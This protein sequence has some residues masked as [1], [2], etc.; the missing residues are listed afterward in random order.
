MCTKTGVD[1]SSRFPFTVQTL[2]D[3]H[4]HTHEVT[5]A[6]D[7]RIP[8]I[9]RHKITANTRRRFVHFNRSNFYHFPSNVCLF[10]L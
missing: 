3:T 8:L 10:K 2:T 4:A 5:D 1:S 6:S 7:H 9:G